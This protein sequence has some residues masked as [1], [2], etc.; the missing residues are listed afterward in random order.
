[1]NHARAEQV[2]NMLATITRWAARRDDVLAVGLV[3]SWARNAAREDSDV[4][5]VILTHTPE[6]YRVH[7]W[8]AEVELEIH[9]WEDADYGP[10]W[11]RHSKLKDG[12][13]IEFGFT[14]RVWAS[15]EPLDAGTQRVVDDG[16]HV[17]FDP[18]RILNKLK[19]AVSMQR[20]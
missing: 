15:L 13:E 12:L 10:L 17:L 20:S 7:D 19:D 2:S 11:S 3:G 1:M 6:A 4:D 16:C 18:E 8:H 9:T 14:T 5:L